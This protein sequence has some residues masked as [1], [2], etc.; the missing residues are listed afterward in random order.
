MVNS[1]SYRNCMIMPVSSLFMLYVRLPPRSTRTDH[2]FPYTALVRSAL[3]QGAVE[4]GRRRDGGAI[5]GPGGQDEAR[6]LPPRRPGDALQHAAARR[7][8][9]LQDRK[10]TRLNSSH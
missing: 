8:I 2:L 10:S 9:G 6:S 1:C 4:Q 3:G 7:E 5:V